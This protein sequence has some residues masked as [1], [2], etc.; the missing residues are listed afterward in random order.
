LLEKFSLLYVDPPWSYR[1]KGNAGKRGASHKYKCL[2]VKDL[3]ALPVGEIAAKDSLL[4]MWWVPPMP[5]EAIEVMK[6]WGFRMANM[7]GLTWRKVPDPDFVKQAERIAR[8]VRGLSY[9]E[10]YR[11][12]KELLIK[13]QPKESFGLGHYTRGNSECVLFAVKGHPKIVDHGIKQILNSPML[14]HSHKPPE[15]RRRLER[16]MGTVPRIELFATSK[17]PGW[18]AEGFEIDGRDIRDVLPEIIKQQAGR[19]E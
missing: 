16:L 19:G 2:K 18:R 13:F 6:A 3:C 5:S 11:V 15:A 7:K 4:A 1:D 9:S 10:R 14:A 12:V 17:T 8:A